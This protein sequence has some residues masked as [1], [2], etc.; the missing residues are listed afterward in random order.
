[1]TDL[2]IRKEFYKYLAVEVRNTYTQPA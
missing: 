2:R 1:M